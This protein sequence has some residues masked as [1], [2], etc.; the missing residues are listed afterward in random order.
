MPARVLE[1]GPPAN[2]LLTLQNNH[3]RFHFGSLDDTSLGPSGEDSSSS[4]N[5]PGKK[6]DPGEGIFEDAITTQKC[7]FILLLVILATWIIG[8]VCSTFYGSDPIQLRNY[9]LVF[10]K[11]L[12]GTATDASLLFDNTMKNEYCPALAQIETSFGIYG[13]RAIHVTVKTDWA[14]NYWTLLLT[15]VVLPTMLFRFT[16]S[17]NGIRRGMDPT[18][19]GGLSTC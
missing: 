18:S 4:G 12:N 6:N 15:A 19:G 14:V 10:D 1:D 5:D 13:Q 3:Y 16:A 7:D 2:K 9:Q 8:C 17:P 11:P